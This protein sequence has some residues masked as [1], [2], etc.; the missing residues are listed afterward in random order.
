MSVVTFQNVEAYFAMAASFTGGE[1]PVPMIVLWPKLG[2]P[3]SVTMNKKAGPGEY[4]AEVGG[5]V[6]VIVSLLGESSETSFTDR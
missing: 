6:T 1:A 4:S 3:P 2:T 5:P